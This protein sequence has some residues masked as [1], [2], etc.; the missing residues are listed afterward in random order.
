M[1]KAQLSE[2]AGRDEKC[3]KAKYSTSLQF[4]SLTYCIKDRL[5]FFPFIYL[6]SDNKTDNEIVLANLAQYHRHSSS[7]YV[8][9]HCL[10]ICVSEVRQVRLQVGQTFETK[11]FLQP[12]S[13]ATA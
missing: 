12:S 9:C 8:H 7:G 1:R 2:G 4:P 13:L 5:G 3:C 11:R 6:F 10:G